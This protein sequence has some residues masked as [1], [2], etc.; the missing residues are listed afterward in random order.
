V[1]VRGVS[2]RY[3]A[4]TAVEDV[5]F[6]IAEGES[7]GLVGPNGAGKSTL[8]RMLCG[9]QRPSSGLVT[10]PADLTTRHESPG[11]HIGFVFDPP[12]VPSSMTPKDLLSIEA[13]SQGLEV[14]RTAQAIEEFDIGTY[15]KR[16][17]GRL[18]TGQRQRVNLAAATLSDPTLLILDE[19]TNGLDIEAIH[20]LRLLLHRRT[21]RGR[22]TI[23]SSHNLVELERMTGRTLV[24]KRRLL[25][26][27]PSVE[28]EDQY[29]ALINQDGE[30]RAR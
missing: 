23:V 20:W 16:A 28:N 12:G 21:A 18:S 14:D 11:R 5:S 4:T 8:L 10:T 26:D 2:K 7:V 19:P 24:L 17:F 25:F 30:V 9:A 29:F 13:R 27:G 3:R 22:T 6:E 15:A 1:L